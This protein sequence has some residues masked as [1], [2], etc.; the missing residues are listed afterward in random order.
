MNT[1]CMNRCN[2]CVMNES[3]LR[4]TLH[5]VV[6]TYEY[7][8]CTVQSIVH[9]THIYRYT[10]SV[11]HSTYRIYGTVLGMIHIIYSACILYIR[12]YV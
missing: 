7:M 2:A 11:K 3:I 6:D 5:S 9:S 8:H 12:T 10:D 1:G 4:H